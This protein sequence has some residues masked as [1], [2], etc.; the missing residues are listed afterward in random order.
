MNEFLQTALGFPTI[1]YSML[2][3]VITL[4]W[5]L[6]VTGLADGDSVDALVGDGHAT[7]A[8]AAAA[9]LSK[10]GLGGVPFTVVATTLVF[11]AWLGAYFVH[12]LVLGGLP[13]GVR[14]LAGI[15]TMV[16]VLVP[17]VAVTSLALRP[18]R[19]ALAKMRPVERSLVGTS[20]VVVTPTLSADYGQ[21]SVD[22]GGAGLI[23]QVRHDGP[24]PLQRG[25]RIVLIEYIESQ[26]AYRV[27]SEQQFLGR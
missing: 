23:L 15:G 13:E 3:A 25:D 22:D 27:V 6:A 4:Y 9:M 21:A 20:A 1:V 11:T 17:A 19:R 7:D 2:L 26:N 5:V 10:L 24:N 18:V 12:L 16:G 8:G 14:T